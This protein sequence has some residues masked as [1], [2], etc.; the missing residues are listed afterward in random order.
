MNTNDRPR[1]AVTYLRVSSL[2]QLNKDIERDGFS[3]PAQRSAC[4][5]KAQALGAVV[6]DEFTER[7]VSAKSTNRRSALGQMLERIKVGDVDYV[8]V[9]KLDRLARNRADDVAIAAAIRD[10]GA[11]LVSVTENIDETPSGS[12][13]H[14]IMSSI[15]E[16]YSKNLAAEVTKGA[17]EKAKRGGTPFRAPLG[18][19]N[20]RTWIEDGTGPA[21]EIRTVDLDPVRAPLVTEAFRLYASGDYSLSELA[22]Y[23]NAKGLRTRATTKTPEQPVGLNRLQQLLRKD[24]YTGVV[25]YRGHAY[26]G[27]HQP[28]TDKATFERVQEVLDA[29]RNGGVRSY[30]HD[31]YLTGLLTCEECNRRLIYVTAKGNG[32]LYEYYVCMGSKDRSCSQPHRRLATMEELVAAEYKKVTLT[33]KQRAQARADVLERIA[34]ISGEGAA[35]RKRATARI[36]EL[37]KQEAKLLE[38]HLNDSVSPDLFQTQQRRIS[39]ERLAAESLVARLDVHFTGAEAGLDAALA[40]THNLYDG[41]LR[42]PDEVRRLCNQAIFQTL[43]I[44]GDETVRHDLKEP[45]RTLASYLPDDSPEDGETAAPARDGGL[46]FFSMVEIR[47]LKPRTSSLP[48]KR[49]I[50]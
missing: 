19:L 45:F 7:G 22:E 17:T 49:S 2:A 36:A 31:H 35:E 25:R 5:K 8:I 44:D 28:L 13:M 14:G 48:A 38:A 10:A 23:L 39:K 12:L 15:A 6:I 26:P 46:N 42:A 40:L 33:D 21:R 37:Q 41:Y 1:T 18:Y 9:H 24:Y 29:Q 27:R 32:G 20:R 3:L 34:N 11:T 50:S 43:Y 30:R 4:E 16:F 47:G